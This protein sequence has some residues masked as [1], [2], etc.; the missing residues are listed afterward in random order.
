MGEVT[1]RVTRS[2]NTIVHLEYM[3]PTPGNLF[4]PQHSQHAPGS[5][6]STDRQN[7]A[8]TRCESHACLVRDQG[9]HL[10]CYDLRIRQY[11]DSHCASSER[12]L[13]TAR[14]STD[15]PELFRRQYHAVGFFIGTGRIFPASIRRCNA[16]GFRRAPG[17][18]GV[19][20]HRRVCLEH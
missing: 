20:E 8:A 7:E 1:V 9:S 14:K 11:F 4:L 5:V 12:V 18:G 2:S 3:N 10:L 13:L 16:C 6:T 19:S 15:A 17:A